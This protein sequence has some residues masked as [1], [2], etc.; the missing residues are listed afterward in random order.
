MSTAESA[1]VL[2]AGAWKTSEGKDAFV[3]VDPRA[4]QELGSFPVSPWSEIDEALEAGARAG[5]QLQDA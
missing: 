2:I 1:E 5:E 4:E 3:S